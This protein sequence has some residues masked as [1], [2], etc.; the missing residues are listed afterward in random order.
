MAQTVAIPPSS[1]SRKRPP[2]ALRFLLH[3]VVIIGLLLSCLQCLGNELDSLRA[4]AAAEQSTT[5][6]IGLLNA[7]ARQHFGQNLKLS[8]SLLQ[9][10]LQL[11]LSQKDAPGQAMTEKNLGTV[12]FYQGNYAATEEHWKHSLAIFSALQNEKGISDLTNNLGVLFQRAGKQDS[13]LLYFSRALDFRTHTKD[14]LGIAACFSN[15]GSIYRLKGQYQQALQQ[16]L[17]AL[18]IYEKLDSKKQLSDSYNSIGLVYNSLKDFPKAIH[19]LSIGLE[20]RKA[21]NDQRGIASSLNNIASCFESMGEYENAIR[22]YAQFLDY[23]TKMNDRRGIAGAYSNL[24]N[25]FKMQGDLTSS[26]KYYQ[27]AAELFLELKDLEGLT[28]ANH[29]IGIQYRQIGKYQESILHFEKAL[30]YAQQFESLELQKAVSVGLGG[31]LAEA[32]RHK[33]AYVHQMRYTEL[34]DSLFSIKTAEKIAEMQEHFEA[35]QKEKAIELLQAA[36]IIE[37]QEAERHQLIRNWAIG[38]SAL[39]LIV[40]SLVFNRARLRKKLFRQRE[41]LLEK[42]KEAYRYTSELQQ[43]EMDRKNRELS[44]YSTATLHKNELLNQLTEKLLEKRD[45]TGQDSDVW[46]KE[47]GALLRKGRDHEKDWTNFKIHF[48]NV[49]PHFFQSLKKS[50]P[51]LTTNDLRNC[52]YIKM[53][54]STK[55]IASLMNIT[56]KSAKMNRYRL[57]KKLSLSPDDSVQEFIQKM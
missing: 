17:K 14:S 35:E 20:Q 22:H 57:K 40:L 1:L 19:Y 47:V 32:G 21:L 34:I 44:T 12:S 5:A 33:E 6:Q 37:K 55:E 7:F 26:I 50:F 49:H 54:L 52:A 46:F 11:S 38:A 10:A 2:I 3:C 18:R 9:D 53:N 28:I 15:I 41:L 24:G 48:E 29:N 56:P 36:S 51:E 30:D 8:Q 23:A 45:L 39:F 25:V 31:V 16:H 27:D 43:L 42:E 4:V 13:S